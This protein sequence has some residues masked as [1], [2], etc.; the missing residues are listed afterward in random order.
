MEIAS[1]WL[2]VAVH[3]PHAPDRDKEVEPAEEMQRK[4]YI[5]TA[6]G[7]YTHFGVL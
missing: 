1:L 7:I 6:G 3:S 4:I 2:E 5:L